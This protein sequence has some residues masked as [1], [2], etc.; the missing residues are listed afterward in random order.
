MIPTPQNG[1][2]R[3]ST[4]CR[5]WQSGRVAASHRRRV[6]AAASRTPPGRSNHHGTRH[7]ILPQPFQMSDGQIMSSQHLRSHIQ[8]NCRKGVVYVSRLLQPSND[9]HHWSPHS[10]QKKAQ[11]QYVVMHPFSSLP[12]WGRVSIRSGNEASRASSLH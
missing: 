3:T 8:G 9:F 11:A 12:C 6:A 4:S 10:R 5:E 1:H 7:A 2:E